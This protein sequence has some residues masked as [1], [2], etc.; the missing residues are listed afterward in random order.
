MVRIKIKR[1][2]EK[3][4]RKIIF[5]LHS[6]ELPYS[7]N[8]QLQILLL[9]KYR[10]LLC[11][12][13]SFENLVDGLEQIGFNVFS[14]TYEDGILLSIFSVIGMT[15][16]RCVDIG[17]GTVLGSNTANLVINHSFKALLIDANPKNIEQSRTYYANH[18]ETR[19]SPPTLITAM[20]MAENV[21]DILLEN[22][23]IDEIDLLCIDIDGVDYWIWNALE[24]I[25][26][27]VVLV[28]YQDIL[29]PNKS[30]TIPYKS[31]FCLHDYDVNKEYNNYCGASLQ[32]FVKLGKL[33]GYRLVG[34]NKGGWNA[35][36]VRSDLGGLYLPE[37]TAESCFKHE[38]NQFGIEKRFPLVRDMDWQEV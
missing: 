10:E 14:S 27:R 18:P 34:C 8:R 9:L 31:N 22:K 3:M 4:L 24:V 21:N 12:D 6:E 11:N 19:I 36:F 29:G 33:K 16:R 35:F 30:L 37:V 1:K 7:F 20:V 2:I 17:A 5:P 25:N 15:N 26:P 38:W 28:E 13:L 23:F 32:A